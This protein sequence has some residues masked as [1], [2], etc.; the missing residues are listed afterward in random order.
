MPPRA[1]FFGT[2]AFS[3][4]CLDALTE[5]AEV[6][7]VVCQPDKPAGRGLTLAPPPVKQRALALGLPVLQPT[8]LKDGAVAAWARDLRADV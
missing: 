4:P 7:G 8:K 6:V 2:P 3:V 1:L 5:V